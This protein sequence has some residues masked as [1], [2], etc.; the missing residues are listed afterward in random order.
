MENDLVVLCHESGVGSTQAGSQ[1]GGFEVAWPHQAASQPAWQAQL[2]TVPFSAVIARL[3]RV[4]Q[5]L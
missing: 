5:E 3:T 2:G 1:N 4:D